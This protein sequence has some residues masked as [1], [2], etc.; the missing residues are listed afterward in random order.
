MIS[1][2]KNGTF[3]NFALLDRS[4]TFSLS[5]SLSLTRTLTQTHTISSLSVFL[6][7]LLRSWFSLCLSRFCPLSP[8]LY[9]SLFASVCRCGCVALPVLSLWCSEVLLI[10]LSSYFIPYEWRAKLDLYLYALTPIL[11]VNDNLF[12]FH[13]IRK[14]HIRTLTHSQITNHYLTPTHKYSLSFFQSIV[15]AITLSVLFF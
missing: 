1:K 4:P 8:S 6:S 14:F 10:I 5:L 12:L 11:F 13:L 9:V 15:L 2:N 3:R 7:P